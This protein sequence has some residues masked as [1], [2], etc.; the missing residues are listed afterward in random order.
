MKA[1]LILL[2]LALLSTSC[3]EQRDLFVASSPQ[4][5]IENDWEPSKIPTANGA[6][7]MI[8]DNPESPL[9][10]IPNSV[11]QML[12]LDRGYYDILVF[13]G[14]MYSPTQSHLDHI[15]YRG[16]ESFDTFE[17]VVEPM[18]PAYRFR[19]GKNEYIVEF[20]DILSTHSTAGCNI[21]GRKRFEIKYRD[22]KNGFP[23]TTEYLEDTIHFSP[24]RVTHTCQVIARVRNA[25]SARIVQA[26]LHG[27]S[28]SVFLAN[29]LP[30]HS[31]VTHQFTLNSLKF[32]QDDPNVG[33]ITSPVF[34]TFGP[35]L[36]LP[37]RK[38]ALEIDILLTNSQEY[39]T[40]YFDVTDQVEKAIEYLKAERLKDRPIMETFYIVV[41][42]ELPP[43]IS[44]NLKVG[45]ADWGND[46]I[47][48][49]PIKL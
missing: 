20:P 2:L 15:F 30:G 9:T 49:I 23:T 4:L 18:D 36:D 24:C 48:T 22:G 44:D 31:S 17:A 34:N 42:Y 10:L 28:G 1:F 13:N 16:T 14:L 8:Y 33:T 19:S 38:Y 21:E 26:K 41:E 12:R 45:V 46:I 25:K 7:A 32:D 40:M 27:F 37:G 6:T 35:P 39:P 3:T 43:V 11:R 47:V 5:M 29:R